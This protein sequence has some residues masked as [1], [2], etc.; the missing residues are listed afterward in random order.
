MRRM[1]SVLFPVYSVCLVETP[2]SV[3]LHCAGATRYIR[4]DR[5]LCI[6]W[7]LHTVSRTPWEAPAFYLQCCYFFALAFKLH[8][9]SAAVLPPR[10]WTQRMQN[11][12]SHGPA[13]QAIPS[14]VATLWSSPL[15]STTLGRQSTVSS[16]TANLTLNV[17]Y[18]YLYRSKTKTRLCVWGFFLMT[19]GLWKYVESLIHKWSLKL[20]CK[21]TYR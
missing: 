11:V 9:A 7:Y 8:V 20:S 6:R 15:Q 4:D 17:Y 19:I 3:R 13:L 5:E 14:M 2:E 18:Q 1:V 10:Y 21:L 12:P 16:Y